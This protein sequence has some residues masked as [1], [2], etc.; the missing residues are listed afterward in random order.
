M[1]FAVMGIQKVAE[2]FSGELVFAIQVAATF[3]D[4]EFCSL[5]SH[6]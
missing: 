5:L 6:S 4:Q 3:S 2:I 1:P